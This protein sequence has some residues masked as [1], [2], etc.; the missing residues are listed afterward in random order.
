MAIWEVG[1]R[2][3]ID[4]LFL[5]SPTFCPPPHTHSKQQRWHTM[6]NQ[7]YYALAWPSGQVVWR[8]NKILDCL[9]TYFSVL[10]LNALIAMLFEPPSWTLCTSK[11]WGECKTTE[12]LQCTSPW[13]S[14]PPFS[15]LHSP[16]E[17]QVGSSVNMAIKLL[18]DHME[19]RGLCKV[20]LICQK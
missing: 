1:L 14:N 8:A 17:V 4:Q 20:W 5:E 6:L 10:L 19:K 18:D 12:G 2:G 11:T 13:P 3:K 15:S 16:H 7:I 9:R